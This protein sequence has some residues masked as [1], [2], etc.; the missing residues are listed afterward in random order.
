MQKRMAF[1]SS[2]IPFPPTHLNPGSCQAVSIETLLAK[3]VERVPVT[4]GWL[5]ENAA[6]QRAYEQSRR[7]HY[8][9]VGLKKL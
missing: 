8:E 7:E 3:P 1:Q 5:A 9:R 4:P 2:T 6:K